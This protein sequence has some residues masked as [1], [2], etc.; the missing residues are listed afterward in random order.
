[1]DLAA[2]AAAHPQPAWSLGTVPGERAYDSDPFDVIAYRG[3]WVVADAAA[4]SLLQ[5]SPSGHISL[6]ARFPAVSEAALAGVFGPNPVTVKARRYR[7]PSR[8][9]RTG[10]CTSGCCAVSRLTRARPTSTASSPA[11]SRP[12]GPAG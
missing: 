8:S 6:L 10:P 5:V 12:S 1:M 11:T 2:Y 4:N 7:P 3:G 9:A